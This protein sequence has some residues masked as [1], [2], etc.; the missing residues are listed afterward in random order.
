LEGKPIH[1]RHPLEQKAIDI[2]K[3]EAYFIEQEERSRR[4]YSFGGT[5]G[6]ITSNMIPLALEFAAT[7]GLNKLGSETAKRAATRLLRRHATTNVGKAAIGTASFLGGASLR[8]A[9]LPHRAAEAIAKRQIPKGMNIN[10]DG[11]VNIE[12][13]GEGVSTSILKGLADH[14]ITVAAE[15]TG[16]FMGPALSKSFGALAN[17]LPVFKTLIPRMQAEWMKKGAGRTAAA[18]NKKVG[19]LTGFHGVT[20]EL[21]EEWIDMNLKAVLDIEG[22]GAE[23][24]ASYEDRVVAANTVFMDNLPAMAVSFMLPGAARGVGAMIDA[25]IQKKIAENREIQR[26]LDVADS[27]EISVPTQIETAEGNLGY[28]PDVVTEMETEA[29]T[30]LK[31]VGIGKYLTPKWLVNRLIGAETM[32]EDVE[33][34]HTAMSL[35]RNDLQGWIGNLVKKLRKEKDLTRLPGILEAEAEAEAQVNLEELFGGE[36]EVA[37]DPSFIPRGAVEGTKAHILQKKINSDSPV[38]I[39]RDLLD[40]YEDAPAFLNE[41]ETGI[42]NQVRELT[43]YLRDRVNRARESRGDEPIGDVKGYITHWIDAAVEE[44]HTRR[45]QGRKS[46]KLGKRIPNYTAEKRKIKQ[47]LEG[48]FSKDLGRLLQQMVKYDLRDIYITK[49]YQEALAELHTLDAMGAVTSNTFRTI[50]NYL[51]YDIREMESE[52]DHMFN[53]SMKKPADLI[54][55]LTFGKVAIDDPARQVFGTLRKLGFV[56]ALGFRLKAPLRNLG[57]RMLL[58]DLYRTRD[59]LQAQ[60]VAFRLTKMPEVAH[61][62]TGETVKLIDLIREQDWYKMTLQKFEDVVSPE[63]TI[64]SRVGEATERLQEKAFHVYA[65][66][67]AGNLFLSNVEVAALTGYFDWQNNMEQSKRGSDHYKA[68]RRY[69][70]K[71]NIPLDVLLTQNEDMLWNI[72]E[73]VRRT[74]WEYFATSMPTIFRGQVAR[75]GFQF[76]SW[77]M[78]YY[79]NHVREMGSQLLTGRNSRG[80]L[81]PGNGRLRALKG[82]GTISAMGKVVEDLLGIAVLKFLLFPDMSR[83]LSAPIPNFI[84]SLAAYWGAENDREKKTALKR[85]KSALRF[86]IPYSLALKDMWELLNGEQDFSD[87]LFYKKEKE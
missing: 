71:N 6:N 62:L 14:W 32:L 29:P 1:T 38:E 67:H 86:W 15:Q 4:G 10:D 85:L 31:D 11:T 63:S 56:S 20:G 13:P 19:S 77:M 40:T 35:E 79:F 70:V 66:S 45:L 82:I 16:E 76:Q 42:F 37:R 48:Y 8:A 58:Q 50:E 84:L 72:R 26:R 75:A 44:E 81:I 2:A 21:G 57:Q 34:S 69:S 28:L 87:L 47:D 54:K 80:R 60:A 23:E 52:L 65:R 5:V 55:R 18:F 73:A 39:M 33:A 74:Q 41:S 17:R 3:L 27:M 22:F 83:P 36:V 59:Y 9:G 24:G 51:K 12:A 68:A 78:N 46:K 25:P 61:P 49:P 30:E 43:R 53:K 64:G 7:G